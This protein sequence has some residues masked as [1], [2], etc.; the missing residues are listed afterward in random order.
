MTGQARIIATEPPVRYSDGWLKH[1]IPGSPFFINESPKGTVFHILEAGTDPRGMAWMHGKRSS[2]TAALKFTAALTPSTPA[3]I[4][5]RVKAITPGDHGKFDRM[6]FLAT[7]GQRLWVLPS[8]GENGYRGLGEAA[9]ALGL[10]PIGIE[11]M[12]G[13]PASVWTV[14]FRTESGHEDNLSPLV[15]NTLAEAREKWWIL[16]RDRR[17]LLGGGHDVRQAVANQ[18]HRYDNAWIFKGSEFIA[19]NGR[20]TCPPPLAVTADGALLRAGIPEPRS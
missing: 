3:D 10:K 7:P 17:N 2:L 13:S 12:F 9:T 19:E 5:A 16:D 14:R 1:A 6:A 11:A 15:L 8:Y 4:M 20:V 18:L